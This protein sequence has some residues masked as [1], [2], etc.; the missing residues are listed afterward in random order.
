MNKMDEHEPIY[1][2]E[3]E[4]D[5]VY[6]VRVMIVDGYDLYDVEEDGYV[7][8]MNVVGLDTNLVLGWTL[9]EIAVPVSIEPG[10]DWGC[11]SC[12]AG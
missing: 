11:N 1:E 10:C 2:N 5:Y 3:D 8:W 7:C 9:G 12:D 4:D 6:V